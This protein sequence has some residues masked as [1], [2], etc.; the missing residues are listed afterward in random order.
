MIN[1]LFNAFVG[2]PQ[3]GQS[4]PILS[5]EMKNILYRPEPDEWPGGDQDQACERILRG[6]EDLMSMSIAEQ[7]LAPVDISLYPTYAYTI[8]YPI[9]LSTI[10][11]RKYS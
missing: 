10:R 3:N 4:L 2:E 1:F 11:V 9:D 6:L 5:R 7:F 8:E